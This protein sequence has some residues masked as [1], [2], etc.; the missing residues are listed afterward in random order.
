MNMKEIK[1]TILGFIIIIIVCIFLFNRKD[2]SS[3]T[4]RETVAEE[5]TKIM[6]E[7]ESWEYMNACLENSFEYSNLIRYEEEYIGEN[8]MFQA[9]VS[10]VMEDGELRVYDDSDGNGFYMDNEYYITDRRSLDKTKI[11]EDDIITIYGEYAGLIGLT[12]AINDTTDYVPSFYMYL[13]DI[14]NIN[15]SEDY[16]NDENYEE[17]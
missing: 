4:Q 1:E 9:Q 15:S 5:N 12:R 11:I 14:E 13:C 16:G 10:Q 3:S 2:D 17:Y 7:D 8:Y 6:T